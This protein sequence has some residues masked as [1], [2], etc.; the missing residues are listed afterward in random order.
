MSF[1]TFSGPIRSGTQRYGAGRNTGLVVL[2]QSTPVV[3]GTL[4]GTACILP[5]G[6]Q[7]LSVSFQTTVVFS[8]ATTVKLTIGSTDITGTATVTTVGVATVTF[9]TSTAALA[10]LSN[11]GTT[12]ATLTYTL[13]GAGLTTGAGNIIVQYVQRADDGA[14]N[15]TATQD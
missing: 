2:A 14:Q 15:P 8:A 4:T 3:F 10:L 11:V 6:A 9:A 7:I 12:D 13:A 5:A 1:S